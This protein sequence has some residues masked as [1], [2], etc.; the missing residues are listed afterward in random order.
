MPHR[1]CKTS[2][3]GILLSIA[4]EVAVCFIQ[5]MEVVGHHRAAAVAPT[6]AAAV[7]RRRCECARRL[8]RRRLLQCEEGS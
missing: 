8:Q 4:A 2:V 7:P 6:V 1:S 5:S 3:L